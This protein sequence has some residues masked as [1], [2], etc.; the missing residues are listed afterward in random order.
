MEAFFLFINIIIFNKIEFCSLLNWLRIQKGFYMFDKINW[1]D[2]EEEQVNPMIK[3]KMIWGDKVMISKLELSDGCI[4]PQHEHENE[5]VTQVI[6]GTI[7]F[8]LGKDKD[9]EIDVHPGES[10]IIPANLPHEALMIGDVV[11][12]DTFSPP[13]ADWIDGS[14]DYLKQK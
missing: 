4:V 5:Q 1:D 2:V 9:Q 13:R 14:D 10:L 6:S 3:R 7:R 12:V 11:E 8:W